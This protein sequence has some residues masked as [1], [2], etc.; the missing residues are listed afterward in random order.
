MTSPWKRICFFDAW[1][2]PVAATMLA[3]HADIET[4]RMAPGDDDGNWQALTGAHA[5]QVLS[6]KDELPGQF[7]VTGELLGRCPDL[8]IVST[9]GAGYDTV[10][11]DACTAAGVLAV[12]QAGANKEAVAEHVLGMMLGLAKRLVEADRAARLGAVGPREDLMGRNIQGKTIGIIGLGHIGTRL[13]ELCRGLFGMRVL[14]YDPYLSE[15]QFR[16]RGGEPVAFDRLLRCSDFV[17]L[18]C[19]RT[20]E[21]VGMVGAP[22]FA[23]MKPEAYFI[24]TARG[25]IHD[26]A[27]LAAAL[28]DGRLAGAGLDVW[29]QEPPPVDHPLLALDNVIITPHTAGVTRES[30]RDVAV[31]CAEQ[32]IASLDGAR[33]PRILNEAAWPRYTERFAAVFGR[34]MRV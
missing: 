34:P 12:N 28:G 13:A 23:L 27:A 32:L 17:S 16:E 25:G 10:D 18:N 22:E 19:P 9:Y 11:L 5:Y 26:E 4:H 15:A 24:S 30:R 1:Q 14:A 2:D 6:T 29:D 7:F 3:E 31:A 33:P 8:M 21:T 20:A